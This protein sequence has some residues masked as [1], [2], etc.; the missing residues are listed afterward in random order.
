[1]PDSPPMKG[2]GNSTKILLDG[3]SYLLRS[4][5]CKFGGVGAGLTW[6]KDIR[7]FIIR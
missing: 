5:T 3:D 1:M 4:E 6:K 2:E 7:N